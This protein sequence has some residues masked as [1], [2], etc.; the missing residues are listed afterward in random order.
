MMTGSMRSAVAALISI[1]A[2]AFAA[3]ALRHVDEGRALI[4][5]TARAMAEE[6]RG[7]E[8]SSDAAV[9]AAQAASDA[10]GEDRGSE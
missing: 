7:A 9:T 8:I 5:P 10:R 1:G 4:G 6:V 3:K 2:V